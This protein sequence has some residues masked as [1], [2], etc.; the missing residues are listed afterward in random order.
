[1]NRKA[2]IQT[3]IIIAAFGGSGIVLYK[4]LG[5]GPSSLTATTPVSPT[6]NQQME[7]ILPYGDTLDFNKAVRKDLFQYKVVVYPVLDPDTEV[8]IPKD[9]LIKPQPV[10]Q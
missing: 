9:Q 3:I 8:G 6:A 1:M 5:G 10:D 4:G 2:I 7:K